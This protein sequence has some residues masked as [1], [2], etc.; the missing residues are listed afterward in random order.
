LYQDTDESSNGDITVE[1]QRWSNCG[2]AFRSI[3]NDLWKV[4]KGSFQ[5]RGAELPESPNTTTA[6]G[7]AF[8]RCTKRPRR[9]F[10]ALVAPP[11]PSNL[12]PLDCNDNDDDDTNV[13]A[14]TT[15]AARIEQALEQLLQ[16]SNHTNACDAG[17]A[18]ENRVEVQN[19]GS[20]R[21]DPLLSKN[22]NGTKPNMV[23]KL[24]NDEMM[25]PN[26]QVE[27]SRH[28]Q[29]GELSKF[30]L[31]RCQ[32]LRMPSVERWVIDSKLEEKDK[33][34]QIQELNSSTGDFH[35]TH[36]VTM[37]VMP[38]GRGVSNENAWK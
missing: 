22:P 3:R 8:S 37:L 16:Q 12:P 25:L 19:S 31:K 21:N 7:E 27:L 28:L 32:F 13:E 6:G 20:A 30:L 24:P 26:I 33:R 29:M 4:A 17:S 38:S 9:K 11:L 2:I 36:L 35:K 14:T 1:I 15:T 18:S 23:S 5:E 10:M 34:F